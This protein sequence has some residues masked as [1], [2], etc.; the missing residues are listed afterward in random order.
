MV[1]SA[2]SKLCGDVDVKDVPVSSTTSEDQSAEHP[3]PDEAPPRHRPAVTSPYHVRDLSSPYFIELWLVSAVATVLGVRS[4]LEL[5]GYP[6]VGGEVLHIAHMLWGGLAMVVAI[7]I[8]T[9]MASAVWK[10]TAA[11]IGGFGFGMFID[12]LGKFITTDNDYFFRPAIALIYAVLV[13]LFLIARTIDRVDKITPSDRMLYAVQCVEQHAIGRLDKE[14]REAGLRHLRIANL[15]SPLAHQLRA[16]LEEADVSAPSARSWILEWRDRAAHL[17]WRMASNRWLWR[18]I[19]AGFIV[20]ALNYL[21]SMALAFR[22]GEF[23]PRDGLSFAESGTL[24]SGFVAGAVAVFGLVMILRNR[25]L[26]GLKALANST[27][28]TLLFGQFFAFAANQFAALG[29]LILQLVILGVLRFWITS[30]I[31]T[32]PG[33]IPN[34]PAAELATLKDSSAASTESAR[35]S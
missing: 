5:T 31:H 3:V 12:E 26:I 35:A 29:S 25:R 20:Q 18:V 28:I 15:D 6:Q 17:Y 33:N 4:Y 8:L 7:G 13:L 34:L 16:I 1:C 27:L 19:L 11:V 9:I 22:G 2:S 23:E 14:G 24:L 10:P 30:E 21:G 32:E